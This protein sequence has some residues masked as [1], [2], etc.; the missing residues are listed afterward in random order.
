MRQQSIAAPANRLRT[1]RGLNFGCFDFNQLENRQAIWLSCKRLSVTF[2]K[3]NDNKYCM[4]TYPVYTAAT[5]KDQPTTA[6]NN[7]CLKIETGNS[8]EKMMPS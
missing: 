7:Q 8:I 4:W 5:L 2:Q 6:C 1:D 3:S